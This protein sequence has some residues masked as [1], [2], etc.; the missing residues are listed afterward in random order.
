VD[1]ASS[2]RV[3]RVNCNVDGCSVACNPDEIVLVAY[4][5]RRRE[6]ATLQTEQQ[7]SCRTRG[8]HSSPLIAACAKVPAETT[9]MAT[10]A[11][12]PR[13][14][15]S[16][17]PAGGVPKFD[18]ASSCRGSA[19]ATGTTASTCTVDEERARDELG[20]RWAQFAPERRTHCTEVSSMSGFQSY[21]E[22]IT[23]LEMAEQAEK[24]PKQ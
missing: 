23:C 6:A 24:L 22:L 12:R 11:T 2:L 14:S 16:R 15:S 3:V 5:G 10:P 21:V 17:R 18:I 20:N 9:G 1:S 7:A 8:A 19:D 13:P 4:C